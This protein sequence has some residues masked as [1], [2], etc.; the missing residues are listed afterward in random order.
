MVGLVRVVSVIVPGQLIQEI[1]AKLQ[2]K[3]MIALQAIIA[4]NSQVLLLYQMQQMEQTN[5]LMVGFGD[6]SIITGLRMDLAL[7]KCV[8][9]E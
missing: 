8:F 2:N 9:R 1:I 7:I 5:V 6:A 4:V 3:F